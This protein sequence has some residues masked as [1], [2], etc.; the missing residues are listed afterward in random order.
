MKYLKLFNENIEYDQSDLEQ[1]LNIARDEGYSVKDDYTGCLRNS[2][3]YSFAVGGRL[4]KIS[5]EKPELSAENLYDKDPKFLP[6]ILDIYQRLLS[7]L[8]PQEIESKLWGFDTNNN[9]ISSY[10]KTIDDIEE[11]IEADE[12]MIS[13]IMR[14]KL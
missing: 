6:M 13:F 7:I 2:K 1:V 12:H 5:I 10:I 9:S 8:E 3:W 14:F 11:L 4:W